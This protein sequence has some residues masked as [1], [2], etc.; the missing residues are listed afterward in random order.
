MFD[1]IACAWEAG[2]AAV[3]RK[4]AP[5]KCSLTGGVLQAIS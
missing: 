4:R 5:P 1:I 3:F 2:T